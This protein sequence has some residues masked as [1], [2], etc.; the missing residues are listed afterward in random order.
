VRVKSKK[1]KRLF[2]DIKGEANDSHENNQGGPRAR[3]RVREFKKKRGV[4]RPVNSKNRLGVREGTLKKG[5]FHKNKK[6]KENAG[7]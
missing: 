7:V 2:S 5:V 4:Y 3:G 1:V 6:P